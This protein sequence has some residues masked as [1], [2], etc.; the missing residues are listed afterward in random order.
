MSDK[1]ET[2]TV[3]YADPDNPQPVTSLALGDSI[4][5]Y[6]GTYEDSIHVKYT[7][8]LKETEIVE[9]H[10]ASYRDII[11]KTTIYTNKI[12]ESPLSG[13]ADDYYIT[14]TEWYQ[15][16]NSEPVDAYDY[17]LFKIADNGAIHKMVHPLF[18]NYYG[19][20]E[21]WDEIEDGSWKTVLAEEETYIYSVNGE[22]RSGEFYYHDTTLVTRVAQYYIQDQ[23]EVEFDSEVSVPFAQVT[24][25]GP[26]TDGI[27]CIN[28][29]DTT[30]V[31]KLVYPPYNCP[32][33]DTTL[34]NTFKITKTR[35]ITM[36]GNGLECG[37]RNTIW[38][39]TEGRG[40]GNPLG[41]VKD[42][43]EIRWS[44]SFRD[45]FG[46]GWHVVSRI[47][48][49]SLRESNSVASGMLRSII[50]PVKY[51]T[52]NQLGGE[53]FLDNDPQQYIVNLD[54]LKE[55]NTSACELINS[56]LK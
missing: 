56:Q 50:N 4:T 9:P 8:I 33:V 40:T 6:Y 24:H 26:E 28:D 54:N 11:R 49:S 3:D 23:Y 53:E 44:E 22:L 18:F 46:E 17:H 42:Q 36:I 5:L 20:Y 25:E 39:G 29:P 45:D 2:Y 30:G 37:L 32:P 19:Y 34:T 1:L 31:G 7:N 15:E 12:V 48:L 14:K 13:E 47:E 52:T 55:S 35:I 21:T 43:L 10:S 16:E 27:V 38:L 41:I 51:L